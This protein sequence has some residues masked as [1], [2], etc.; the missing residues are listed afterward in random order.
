MKRRRKKIKW[1]YINRN[2]SHHGNSLNLIKIRKEKWANNVWKNDKTLQKMEINDIKIE[3]HMAIQRKRK[4]NQLDVKIIELNS[5][6][7]K[8]IN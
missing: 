4:S 2:Y 6:D 1:S 3:R 8:K 5:N 7:N